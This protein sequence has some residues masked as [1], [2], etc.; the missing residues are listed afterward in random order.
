MQQY[1]SA[2]RFFHRA[3]C[4][5]VLK[6]I[7]MRLFRHDHS[8]PFACCAQELNS[9]VGLDQ[10]MTALQVRLRQRT[11]SFLERLLSLFTTWEHFSFDL[12]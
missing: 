1:T 6:T 10:P 8:R 11:D 7:T 4:T 5:A 9:G 12:N 2:A 3:A